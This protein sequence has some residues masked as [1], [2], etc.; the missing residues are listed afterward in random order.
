MR[1]KFMLLCVFTILVGCSNSKEAEPIISNK[2]VISNQKNEQRDA[3]VRIHYV[4]E[5]LQDQELS[6]I[7]ENLDKNQINSVEDIVI[8]EKALMAIPFYRN[9][10]KDRYVLYQ[11]NN[12]YLDAQTVVLYVNIGIDQP[13]YGD[14][15][16]IEDTTN[17]LLLV[18]KFNRLPD[19]YAP[20]DLV[21]TPFIC[22]VAIHYACSGS[23]LQYVRN[24][25]ADPFMKL[26]EAAKAV[27]IDLYSISSYRTYAYQN[28]L[29]TSNLNANGQVYADYN[30]ARAGH[31]EHNTGLALDVSMNGWNFNEIHYAAEYPWLVENMANYGFILRYPYGK[32]ELTGFGYEPWHLRYVGIELA[33]EIMANQWCLEEYYATRIEE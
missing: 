6:T 20:V 25:V 29:Y 19:N 18:N 32:T 12:P 13:F 16:T 3:V 23:S 27:N 31:S 28:S 1:I 5:T 15:K 9:S 26:V 17:K 11:Q 14:V 7:E 2:G 21:S 30:F 8:D 33:Q 22:D 10:L 4:E 24:E